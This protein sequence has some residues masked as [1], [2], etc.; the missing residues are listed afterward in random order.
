[1][2]PMTDRC[3]DLSK[4][5]NMAEQWR[6]RLPWNELQRCRMCRHVQCGAPSNTARAFLACQPAFSFH[7]KP[8]LWAVCSFLSYEA[9]ERIHAIQHLEHTRDSVLDEHAERVEDL[10]E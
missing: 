5:Q 1:M 7:G 3:N 4:W 10:D 2:C 8:P 9:V 6:S